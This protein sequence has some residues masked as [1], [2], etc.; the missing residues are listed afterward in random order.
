VG[1][2]QYETARVPVY[3]ITYLEV[4]RSKRLTLLVGKR[5]WPG[6]SDPNG[7]PLVIFEWN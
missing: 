6:D 5:A 7:V 3:L 1:L 2:H 4:R